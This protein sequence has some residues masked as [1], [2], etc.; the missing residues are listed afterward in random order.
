MPPPFCADAKRRKFE[1]RMSK[2]ET[3]GDS[4][5]ISFGF[6]GFEIRISFGGNSKHECSKLETAAEP[7]HIVSDFEIRISDFVFEHELKKEGVAVK[8]VNRLFNKNTALCK[9]VRRR[10]GCDT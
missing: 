10:I 4:R 5:L 8:W 6:R 3:C 2:F 7:R 9:V 1:A